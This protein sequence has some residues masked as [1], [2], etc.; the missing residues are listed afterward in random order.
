LQKPSPDKAVQHFEPKLDATRD[1][2]EM[3]YRNRIVVESCHGEYIKTPVVMVNVV[4]LTVVSVN[5]NQNCS[6]YTRHETFCNKQSLLFVIEI[7]LQLHCDFF[8]DGNKSFGDGSKLSPLNEKPN[9]CDYEAQMCDVDENRK[10][11]FNNFRTVNQTSKNRTPIAAVLRNEDSNCEN[12]RHDI[13]KLY[14]TFKS[15]RIDCEK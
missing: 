8:V 11:R 4:P 15:F 13:R 6:D 12:Y 14:F 3:I 1:G 5:S 7:H 2:D 9:H 10:A